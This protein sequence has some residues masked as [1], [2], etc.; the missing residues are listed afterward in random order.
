MRVDR[1]QFAASDIKPAVPPNL[2]LMRG[3][4]PDRHPRRVGL[5]KS[6]NVGFDKL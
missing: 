1:G 6:I 5:M 3:P 2:I 4:A